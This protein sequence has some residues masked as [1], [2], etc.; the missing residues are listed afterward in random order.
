MG[1]IAPLFL[2]SK[3]TSFVVKTT[4][5]QLMAKGDFGN[6][7]NTNGLDKKPENINKKGRPSSRPLK[8][9]LLELEEKENK[10]QIPLSACQ[11]VG[12]MVIIKLPSKEN[13]AVTLFKNAIKDV[14][15]FQE[16]AK[17]TG[18]Y[19]AE[20]HEHSGEIKTTQPVFNFKNL[21]SE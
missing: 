19:S 10:I 3:L 4:N 6:K 16:W 21:N 15:W 9:Y 13:M 8:E 18:E 12:D 1:L 2:M 7:R 14:R 20:K 17:I 11:I 5:I